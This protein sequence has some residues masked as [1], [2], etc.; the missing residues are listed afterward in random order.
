MADHKRLDLDVF[1]A[2]GRAAGCAF[3]VFYQEFVDG[4][5]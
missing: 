5:A 4:V 2:A 1:A 3:A